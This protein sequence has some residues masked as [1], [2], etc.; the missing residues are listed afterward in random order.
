MITSVVESSG[1][2]EIVGTLDS[3]PNADYHLE[4][5]GSDKA[6]PSHFGEGQVFLGATDVST[7]A[8]GSASFDV[9]LRDYRRTKDNRDGH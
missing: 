3:L 6:D 9:T 4:F 5:F 1:S 2:V 8:S 7:N